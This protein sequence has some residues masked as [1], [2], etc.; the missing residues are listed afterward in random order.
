M[1]SNEFT[2]YTLMHRR[3]LEELLASEEWQKVIK[4]GLVDE[5][6]DG[7]IE[8]KK[9]R[10][11]VD[12]VVE[13]LV[14]FN[15]GKVKEVI[16][17][18]KTDEAYLLEVLSQ[19]PDNLNGKNTRLS[20]FGINLSTKCN[21]YPNKCV[22]CNQAEV[23]AIEDMN[24]WKRVLKEVTADSGEQGPYVY[25]T[26]GEPLLLEDRLYGD[27]GLVRYATEHGA[28]VNINTNATMLTP[29]VAL[30]LIKSGLAK[31]HISFDSPERD[32]QNY[33]Y[34]SEAA[35]EDRF[36]MLLR[37]I[38]N[39]Q[40]A[41][42]L[43]MVSYPVIHTN[44]VL[45]NLNFRQFPD[46]LNFIISKRKRVT[47]ENPII[48]DL[49]THVIPMGGHGSNDALRLTEEEFREFYT[50]I[51]DKAKQIWADHQQEFPETSRIT[52]FGY[53]SS[54]FERVKHVGGLDA[55]AV[56]SAE[57]VYSKL[58][59]LGRCYVAPTQAAIAPDGTRYLC[60]SHAIHQHSAVGNISERGVYDNIRASIPLLSK[61]SQEDY[62]GNCALATLYINQNVES[63]LKEKISVWVKKS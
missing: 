47:K 58:A 5:V 19:W 56:T 51:W 42:D 20:F 52:L 7:R 21:F 38:Y 13:Q 62:C 60:G 15:E 4:T 22:Y 54:P 45:N 18:G 26:G 29:E 23:S 39:V 3:E 6:R 50:E 9:V 32:I 37:G 55:Y 63:R 46:M 61:L 12:T 36:E 16:R 53:F 30:R 28:G 40:I 8:P 48:Q 2:D 43:V 44:F 17:Q 59:L 41:R 49:M 57:G 31:L 35:G 14:E 25:F 27:D 10:N 34:K 11:Y 33:L 24:V 1:K